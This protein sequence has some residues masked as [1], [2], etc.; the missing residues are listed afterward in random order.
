MRKCTNCS[1]QIPDYYNFCGNC[2]TKISSLPKKIIIDM[3][4][5]G[6]KESNYEEGIKIGLS[7]KVLEK[8][9]YAL[10]EVKLGV[11]VDTETGETTIV[12]VDGQGVIPKANVKKMSGG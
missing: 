6:D 1:E 2:G 5:H 11:E 4:L 7:P 8:F 9:S 12:S 10:Y 3:Y